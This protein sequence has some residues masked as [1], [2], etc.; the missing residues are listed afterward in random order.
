MKVSVIIT[1]ILVAQVSASFFDVFH[2]A[3]LTVQNGFGKLLSD[4]VTDVKETVDCTILAVEHVLSLSPDATARYYE[5]CGTNK[6]DSVSDARQDA[7]LPNVEVTLNL[8]SNEEFL[9]KVIPGE[10]DEKI[11]ETLSKA[12]DNYKS[13]DDV[14]SIEKVL[15]KESE[16]LA[17]VSGLVKKELEKLS[18]KVNTDLKNIDKQRDSQPSVDTILQEIKVLEKRELTTKNITEANEI[19]QVINQLLGK[20]NAIEATEATENVKL[21][22]ILKELENNSNNSFVGLRY[23]FE[24]WKEQESRHLNEIISR[25]DENEKISELHNGTYNKFGFNQNRSV[26]FIDDMKRDDVDPFSS[27]LETSS[28]NTTL[29]KNIMDNTTSSRT[30]G[31]DKTLISVANDVLFSQNKTFKNSVVNDAL[32]TNNSYFDIDRSIA[33]EVIHPTESLNSTTLGPSELSR[34]VNQST[35]TNDNTNE[36]VKKTALDITDKTPLNENHVNDSTTEFEKQKPM[37]K[38]ESTATIISTKEN[39]SNKTVITSNPKQGLEIEV[40]KIHVK[41]KNDSNELSFDSAKNNVAIVRSAVETEITATSQNKN[42]LNYTVISNKSN[43]AVKNISKNTTNPVN[44]ISST[45]STNELVSTLAT[46]DDINSNDVIIISSSSSTKISTLVNKSIMPIETMSTTGNVESSTITTIT[47]ENSDNFDDTK[48]MSTTIPAAK[49]APVSENIQPIESNTVSIKEEATTTTGH[50]NDVV[51]E[52]TNNIQPIESNT[53][54]TKE[55]TMT[56]GHVNDIVIE[57]TNNIQPIES[58]TASTKEEATTTTGHYSNDVVIEETSNTISNNTT[59]TSYSSPIVENSTINQTF[60]PNET[61][62]TLENEKPL[63]TS[64][65]SIVTITA[66]PII[67]NTPVSDTLEVIELITTSKITNG[68]YA[69]ITSPTPIESTS[70]NRNI[71]GVNI[72]TFFSNKV[73]SINSI[74][75]EKADG[76]NKSKLNENIAPSEIKQTLTSDT[77]TD[78]DSDS[79][80]SAPLLLTE[81][82]TVNEGNDHVKSTASAKNVPTILITK[83]AII[84]DEDKNENTGSNDTVTN[85]TNDMESIQKVEITTVFKEQYLSSTSTQSAINEIVTT[86]ITLPPTDRIH[87][88]EENLGNSSRLEANLFLRTPQDKNPLLTVTENPSVTRKWTTV[89][90]LDQ[91][92]YNTSGTPGNDSDYSVSK[93]ISDRSLKTGQSLIDPEVPYKIPLYDKQVLS[94]IIRGIYKNK[95]QDADEFASLDAIDEQRLASPLIPELTNPPKKPPR[96]MNLGKPSFLS[97]L[98][99]LRPPLSL[100]DKAPENTNRPPGL[101]THIPRI[102]EPRA[103][104]YKSLSM[105][106]DS[107]FHMP[108]RNS[109]AHKRA[110][111]EALQLMANSKRSDRIINNIMKNKNKF[112]ARSIFNG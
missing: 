45:F 63:T 37:A 9:Q 98:Y 106:Y 96:I 51:I 40:V 33:N 97:P 29:I 102:T 27:Y 42:N 69:T 72:T 28:N 52:E 61:I 67:E 77:F 100:N 104:N 50:I 58:N 87:I 76:D 6:T 99:P 112:N 23:Q 7:S 34:S 68:T 41:S 109:E 22:E 13:H 48:I 36:A 38:W 78:T 84:P 83:P 75:T 64:N 24:Q 79:I 4:V 82:T 88:N 1:A 10:I 18:N 110:L 85:T 111:K 86:S 73:E 32:K 59:I 16:Q 81:I 66:S 19:H 80:T 93:S 70:K 43:A 8:P 91:Q 20:L 31:N 95:L 39:D 54:S 89:N 5:K 57:E 103:K 30:F 92:K 62:T 26:S 94:P 44:I 60:G 25:I 71:Q 17:G 47:M 2:G 14:L 12:F 35:T 65:E 49:Y 56:T 105:D 46:F 11:N 15:A 53:G 21:Q 107:F 108:P 101:T 55:A 3:V 90:E 74:A